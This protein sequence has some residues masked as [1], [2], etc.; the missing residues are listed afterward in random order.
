MSKPKTLLRL[1]QIIGDA[2]AGISP[3]IPISEMTWRRGMKSGKF[4]QPVKFGKMSFWRSEDIDKL[5]DEIGNGDFDQS[6]A[7]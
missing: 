4:P 6:D 2:E 1:R 7:A 5:V 3:I